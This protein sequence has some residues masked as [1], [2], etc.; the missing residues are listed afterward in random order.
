MQDDA[1]GGEEDFFD[2]DSDVGAETW[3]AEDEIY[4]YGFF[5]YDDE[6]EGSDKDVDSIWE[7]LSSD[8]DGWANSAEDGW[9]Y[10]D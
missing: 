8:Q 6:Y 7:D 2:S 10:E 3:N 5:G 1:A 4:G 9:F